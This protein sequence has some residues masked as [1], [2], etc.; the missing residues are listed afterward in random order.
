VPRGSAIGLGGI[1]K[2]YIVD[3]AAEKLR[4]SGLDAFLVQAGG[5]LYGAGRKPDGARWVSGIRD[6]RGNKADFFATIELEDRAFSTAGDYARSYVYGGKR[7][8]HIID[9]KTGRPA[10]ASRSVTVWAETAF[11]A[12]AL[13]D[14]VFVMGPIEGLALIE[15]TPGAGAVIVD[16]QN[17]VHVSERLRDRVRLTHPPTDGI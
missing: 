3:K 14:A 13:D 16:A 17:R 6:P 9:P 5:D 7:Y 11:L 8:H 1:A 12:D 2:G 10:M 4:A 15:R